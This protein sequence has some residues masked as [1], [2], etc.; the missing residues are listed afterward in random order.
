MINTV[1]ITIGVILGLGL[2]FGA[3][4]LAG[5][6]YTYQ[7]TL[8][9]PPAPAAEISLLDQNGELFRLSEQ[10]RQDGVDF[11]WLHPLSRMSAQ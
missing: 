3:W 4:L 9:D 5:Q 1:L 6:N 7:G 11:L 2:V 8:I 10:R